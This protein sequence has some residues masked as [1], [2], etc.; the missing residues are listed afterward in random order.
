MFNSK[1]PLLTCIVCSL[2]LVGG[3]AQAGGKIEIDDTKWISIG[4]AART[5]FR[6]I[7]DSAPNGSDWSSDFNLD[8]ARIY[9]NGQI[10]KN[11][12]FELN[13]ECV[14]CGNSGIPPEE[15]VILDAIA[16]FEFSPQFNIWAGRMLVP[17]E[18]QELNGP[19]YSTTYDAFKTPFYSS[20]FSTDF[21]TAGAGVYARDHG[22]NLWGALGSEGALQYV[23]G[24]F[25]GLESAAGTGPNQD[26][27][28]LYAG[29][30]AYNFLDVEKN[31]GYYTSGTYYGG[32]GDIF[33]V[34]IAMQYQEDG[35]GTI[36]NPGDFFGVSVD[37]LFEKVLG[38]QGVFTF[39][40]E[41]KNFSSDY[42]L[43][44]FTD[45]SGCFCMFDGDSYSL[46]GLYL[47]PQK[48][49]IGKFQPYLRY[50][51]I[52]PDGSADRDEF[53]AG[54]NYIIDGHNARVSMFYQHG[55]IVTKGLTNYR[56]TAGGAT[57]D[58]IR[59]AIQL[60]I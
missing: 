32:G 59:I 60:Q 54:L 11:I 28:L 48:I 52:D 4:A 34:G 38:N 55:D 15:Y 51:E 53:E 24:I 36:L 7:E 20:D 30:L 27:N 17:A 26:D 1:R 21:G 58:A 41:Y 10:H 25:N 9:I 39:N 31:P 5:S 45:G 43:A 46:V 6:T 33:T 42:A 44:A 2:F 35:S 40:G 13:T 12:K 3:T 19:Y 37:V 16:K 14:F 47:F 18:R 50:T 8:S 29:R 49:G 56:P 23:A 57:V 22:V